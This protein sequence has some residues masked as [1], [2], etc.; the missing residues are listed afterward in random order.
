MVN[1]I[2]KINLHQNVDDKEKSCRAFI[3]PSKCSQFP[4]SNLQVFHKWVQSIAEI[5][6]SPKPWELWEWE[7]VRCKIFH[8]LGGRKTLWNVLYVHARKF[9]HQNKKRTLG[10]WKLPF[11]NHCILTETAVCKMT[12]FFKYYIWNYARLPRD[13]NWMLNK[14][15]KQMICSM[16]KMA[17]PFYWS[18][19]KW[20]CPVDYTA[21]LKHTYMHRHGLSEEVIAILE[22]QIICT[23]LP[24]S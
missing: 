7:S 12:C 20:I 11:L 3:K 13:K 16:K 2:S 21:L 17:F 19:A 24:G 23:R 8:A 10:S 9:Y 1:D 5:Q 14:G 6:I 18:C 15:N 22:L 4:F